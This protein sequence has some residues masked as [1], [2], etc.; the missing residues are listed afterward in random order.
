MAR[1]KPKTIDDALALFSTGKSPR[2]CEKLTG[3]PATTIDR[4]AKKR[5]IIKGSV[6]QL[7]KDT[8]RVRSEFGEQCDAVQDLIQMEVDKQLAGME[9]YR[10]HARKVVK[11]GFKSFAEAPSETGMKTVLDGMKSGMQVEGLVP[12]YPSAQTINNANVAQTQE[13]KILTISDFYG[14]K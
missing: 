9:F 7:I 6:E 1:G 11:I 14:E 2:E 8:V 5:G 12:F 13:T 4:H 10:T 3:I